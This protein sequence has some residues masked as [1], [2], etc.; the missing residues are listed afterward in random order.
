MSNKSKVLLA[1]RASVLTLAIASAAALGGQAWAQTSAAA[2]APASTSVQEVIV[3]ATRR[4]EKLKD[5]PE[6]VSVL[7]GAPLQALATGGQ[8][9]RQLAFQTPSLN[10]E[11][12]N[13]RTFPRFYIRG[14]GN[15]DFNSFASQPVSLLYDDIV[16]EN[17]ALKG[18][19]VFDQADVEVL[20]GP[21][22]TLFGRNTPAGVVKLDSAKPQLGV[23][24]GYYNVSDATYNTAN[25]QGALNVPLADN[26]ALRLSGQEQHRDNWVDDPVNKT[27]LEGYDDWAGRAQLL[28]KPTDDF[29][30]LVN[31]HGRALRGSARLFRANI[32][33]PGGNGLIKG[34]D[35]A[36][37][38]TDGENAQTFGS[39]GANLHLTWN[40]KGVTLYSITGYESILH[41]F[42]EGDIDGG[43]FGGP[44]LIFFPVETA[45]G[46]AHHDQISQEFRAASS[47]PGP[48]SW[49]AGVFLFDEDV[50]AFSNDYDPTG[51]YE[52]DYNTARQRNNA[53]AVFGSVD[54]KV[55]ANFKL[56]GGLRFTDDN[57]TFNSIKDVYG[58]YGALDFP[59][60]A[61]GTTILPPNSQSA[62]ASRLNY[63]VSGVY[64]IDPD[65]NVYARV[66]SGF[67]AASFGAP[68]GT[69]SNALPIQVA[70]PEDVT[71]YETGVKADLFDH[72]ARLSFDVFYY[73][74]E[75]QQLTA[76]GGGANTTS[77][78]NAKRTI[79]DGAELDFQAHPTDQLSF[80][81]A[82]SYNNTKIED[83]VLAVPVCA[84]CTVTN[85]LNSAGNAILNG[86]PLPQAA[87]WVGD[88]TLNYSIPLSAT[89]Q[90][91]FYTDWSYRSG[92]NFFLYQSKEFDGP[93]LLQGGLR[94]GYKW[95]GDKYDIAIFCRNCTNKIVAIGGIDFDDN[96]GMINDPRI[97]GVQ[98]GGKF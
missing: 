84:Q 87:K 10:I 17:P 29:T 63:D 33:D 3:T 46:I 55:T 38:Y 54:Y 79:G 18:F 1:S 52:T 41:Y 88:F 90:A 7:S 4:E 45:G 42:T 71:S 59:P 78:I 92:V 66:A 91:Y 24:G 35:P 81:F 5:V 69:P 34:F 70:Q 14:Y 36:K 82:G 80:S 68:S 67:R 95:A 65:V 61:P 98:F 6:S 50:T 43:N 53:E 74:V 49:Q 32:I 73:D 64:T 77:L 93:E 12:S 72:R 30:A 96:T 58:P 56:T 23:L 15:T 40:L 62:H 13:G 8:D 28:Y 75:H 85:A 48:L 97:V 31:V 16:Q 19:P 26:L 60:G 57:K 11:S 27:H 51:A 37:I 47:T 83:P 9:I 2:A 39:W 20:R 89:S 25:V 21:Q 94:L 76:V 22:G 86:N 44:G